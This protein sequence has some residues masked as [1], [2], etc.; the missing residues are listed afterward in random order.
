MRSRLVNSIVIAVTAAMT[1][2]VQAYGSTIGTG[3]PAFDVFATGPETIVISIVLTLMAA[4]GV[5]VYLMMKLQRRERRLQTELTRIDSSKDRYIRELITLCGVYLA[6]LD[7]FN[8][9]AGRKIKV[10]QINDLLDMIESGKIIREQ[11]Q[12]FYEVFDEAFLL[13]YPCFVER[14]NELLYEDRQLSLNDGGYLSTELRI[15][16]FMR[17][18]VNDSTQIAKFL[19]L[20]LNT[21]YTYRN[22]VKSR[23]LNRETFETDVMNIKHEV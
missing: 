2:S 18:G 22:K 17:L 1:S 6:A 14:V 21:V 7:N 10:G 16:A 15:L 11:L 20:S 4:V 12:K 3:V 13:V 19:G 9:L 23:A 5:L 8:K